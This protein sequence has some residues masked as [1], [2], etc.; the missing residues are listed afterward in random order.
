MKKILKLVIYL[1]VAICLY[2]VE[3]SWEVQ[4]GIGL[5][6]YKQILQVASPCLNFIHGNCS[7]ASLLLQSV[8]NKFEPYDPSQTIVF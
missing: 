5:F 3:A 4:Y 1:L 2:S 7:P 8:Q 6:A